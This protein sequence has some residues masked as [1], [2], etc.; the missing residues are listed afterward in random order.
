MYIFI[1]LKIKVIKFKWWL[2]LLAFSGNSNAIV[3]KSKE[4]QYKIQPN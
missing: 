4:L 2:L 1:R 3:D